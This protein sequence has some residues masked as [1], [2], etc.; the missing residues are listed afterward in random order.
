MGTWGAGLY[1]DDT[2]SDLRDAVKLVSK[3]PVSGDKLL[4]I[5]RD[6]NQTVDVDDI[7]GQTFWLVLADQFE[8]RG[9]ACQEVSDTAVSLIADGRNLRSL[10]EHGAQANVLPAMNGA[11]E[12][13]W[14]LPYEGPFVANGWGALVVLETGRA[15]DWLPWCAVASLTVDPTAKPT[16][17][18]AIVERLIFH[19]QTDGAA[20]CIPRRPEIKKMNLELLGRVD[21]D[22]SRVQP[23]LS[24][25]S[26]G[27]AIE[28]GWCVN[29][30]GYTRDVRGLPMGGRLS[31]LLRH[32]G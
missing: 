6:M 16:L 19:L 28:C 27:Q 8:R 30:A 32:A 24:K 2:A 21:L 17:Q 25:W 29:Y 9:I 31:E 26:V 5:L 7:D 14:R 23:T 18:D 20:R 13:P 1:D 15:F 10:E 11:A 3:V 4:S 22:S 12:H